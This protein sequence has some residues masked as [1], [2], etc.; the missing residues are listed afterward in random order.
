MTTVKVRVL[1]SG[2]SKRV[3]AKIEEL[4]MLSPEAMRAIEDHCSLWGL[5]N[6]TVRATAKNT[7]ESNG[8]DR[9]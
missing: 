9:A 4:I 8:R 3:A 6:L 1:G 7:V 5:L 2:R